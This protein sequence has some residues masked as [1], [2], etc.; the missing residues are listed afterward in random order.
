MTRWKAFRDK[1]SECF[2]CQK[3]VEDLREQ[4]I[5]MTVDH[6]LPKSLG[7]SNES[8]NLVTACEKCNNCKSDSTKWYEGCVA[9]EAFGNPE[10]YRDM[11]LD[12]EEIK[13]KPEI[14]KRKKEEE[15][16]YDKRIIWNNSF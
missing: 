13:K 5:C 3:S 10:W 2:Y 15:P 7:G 11:L 1:S 14:R 8:I 12:E 6:V 4:G 9:E 16:E